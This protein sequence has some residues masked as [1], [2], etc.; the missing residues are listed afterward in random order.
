MALALDGVLS[1]LES[2]SRIRENQALYLWAHVTGPQVAAAS[3]AAGVRDG[4]LIV[5]TRSSVWSQQLSFMKATILAELNKRIGKPVLR[6]IVF[7]AE[8]L[9]EPAPAETAPEMPTEEELGAVQ[10]PPA[11]EAALRDELT[12]LQNIADVSLRERLS[13]CIA[14]DRRLRH[15]RLQHGW[16]VCRECTAV[17]KSEDELCPICRI[18]R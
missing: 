15:W 6:D 17:H 4:V 10:L 11:E 14:R 16:R 3:E 8:G 18:C 2:G 12:H 9:P 5:R 1:G 13:R 7:R